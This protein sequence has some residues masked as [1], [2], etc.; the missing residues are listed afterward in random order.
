MERLVLIDGSGYFY[1]AFWAVKGL[2]TSSGMPTNAIFGFTNMLTRLMKAYP[3]DRIIMVFDAPGPTFRHEEYPE[4]KATRDAMP[5]EL[6]KQLPF[7]KALPP[8]F[9]LPP[10]FSLRRSSER[11]PLPSRSF[12]R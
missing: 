2:A 12:R 3:G 10:T 9:G 8:A 5:E 6:V 4:Y 1:R 11:F 7:I